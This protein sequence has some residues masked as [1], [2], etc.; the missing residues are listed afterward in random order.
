MRLPVAA[1]MAL[2]SA[3]A[4]SAVLGS[5]MPPGSG[6][7]ARC[8]SRSRRL[9]VPQHLVVVEVT[10]H[11][12]A[13]LNRDLALQRRGQAVDRAAFHLRLDR[14]GIDHPA[15]SRP[16]T[17]PCGP[18]RCRWST[19]TSATCPTMLPKRFH[20]RDAAR[21]SLRQRLAPARLSRRPAPAPPCGAGALLSWS[22]RNSNGS[23]PAA[24]ASSSMNASTTKPLTEAPTDRQKPNG[25]P[26][27]VSVYSIRMFGMSY[28][29]RRRA[30]DR[31]EVDAVR[32]QAADALHQRLLDDALHERRPACPAAS[33]APHIRDVGDRTVEVVLHVV[34]ARPHDLDRL[35]DGLRGLDR[36]GDEV[37]LAA[38]AESAAEVRRVNLDLVR[39]QARWRRSP[40]GATRSVPASAPRRRSRSA[41]TSAVQFI[42][43]IVACARNGTSKTRSNDFAAPF[44]AAVGVAV[45][46][47]DLAG[48]LAP[49][50]AY[51]LVMSALFNFASGP[52]SH[53]T[54]SA[55][56]PFDA[57][58]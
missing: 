30:V 17:R 28:G 47:R 31:D 57:A 37:G 55:C 56:A 19:D 51:F 4:A 44:S 12:A 38:P 9:V 43:S 22:R 42:G 39:R 2:T 45:V 49:A 36:V 33:T 48:L 41:R 18:S 5:P 10:L 29:Q 20:Q 27:S 35:A 3:P 54:S 15:R 32:R 13:V 25:M 34:F 40:P 14:V 24:A 1:A 21:A 8:G 23:S 7:S 26:G 52:S 16:R 11:D 58:Q 50:R 6:G 53:L 46:A